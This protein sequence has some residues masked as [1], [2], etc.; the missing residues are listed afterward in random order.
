MKTVRMNFDA[1]D[2][3]QYQWDWAAA[4][5]AHTPE[6]P[7]RAMAVWPRRTGKDLTA[8]H[9]TMVLAHDKVGMYWHCL[10]VYEQARK[11]CWNSF[12]TDMGIRLMDNVFPREIRKSPTE[13]TPGSQM[14]LVELKGGSIIQF[15]GSDSIDRLVG[16]GLAGVNMSEFALSKPTAWPLMQ[17]IL[18]ESRGWA[19]FLFTPRSRNHAHKLFVEYQKP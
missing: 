12:R 19:T 16:A 8:L 2:P 6:E 4:V 5:Q 10:P 11:A 1:F 13:F 15:V 17:P 9:N 14:M 7:A 18:R 3:R